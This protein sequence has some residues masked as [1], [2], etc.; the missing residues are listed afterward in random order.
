MISKITHL[1][2]FVQ[3]QNEALDFYINKIGFKVHTDA[4]FGPD[5]RWLTVHP[6]GQPDFELV[7]MPATTDAEKALVGKQGATKPF[8]TIETDSCQK[9]YDT[10][11]ARGVKFS[12]AP[13]QQPWGVSTS[14][15]D[16]YGNIIYMVQPK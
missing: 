4:M 6:E 3:N 8:F 13:E 10:L 5:F 9:D 12:T 7:L 2:L 1:T 15:E 14:F 11:L 16:L